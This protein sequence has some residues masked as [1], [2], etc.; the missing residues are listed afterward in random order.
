[1]LCTLGELKISKRSFFLL[2]NSHQTL[3]FQFHLSALYKAAKEEGDDEEEK[4]KME[5]LQE[6][7]T[8]HSIN[9]IAVIIII[10][11]IIITISNQLQPAA[12]ECE[13][14]IMQNGDLLH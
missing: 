7:K 6:H 2:F 3:V 14:G 8:H 5:Q 1:M 10:I 11:T 9:I 13:G 4:N 12:E